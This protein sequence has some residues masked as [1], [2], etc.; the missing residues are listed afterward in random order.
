MPRKKKNVDDV[1]GIGDLEG[2]DF[3][4]EELD[5]ED[6]D[7]SDDGDDGED[8]DGL[9]DDEEDEEEEEEE[10]DIG[11][12]DLPEEEEEEGEDGFYEIEEPEPVKKK[13]GRPKGSKNKKTG[14]DMAGQKGRTTS[15][16]AAV[17]G[18]AKRSKVAAK[19][20]VERVA[21]A[22]ASKKRGR[23]KG[24]KNKPARVKPTRPGKRKLVYTKAEVARRVALEP[25]HIGN[26]V[27]KWRE[28]LGI[29]RTA[30]AEKLGRDPSWISYLEGGIRRTTGKRLTFRKETETML[31]LFIK[32]ARAIVAAGVKKRGRPKGS[33]NKRK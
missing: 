17:K 24:S 29:T 14:K 3:E 31:R 8:I 13:R 33:K 18:A 20:E 12:I 30:L 4:D 16:S 7:E 28:K 27:K 6:E 9:E 11:E 26:A 10:D 25:D 23:P 22:H 21:I 32:E 15:K 1:D 5:E 19:P 2:S